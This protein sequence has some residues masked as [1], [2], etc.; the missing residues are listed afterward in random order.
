MIVIT[1][2][3]LCVRKKHSDANETQDL[4]LRWWCV[5]L[6][7]SRKSHVSITPHLLYRK[8]DISVLYCSQVSR[9]MRQTLSQLLFL[10]SYYWPRIISTTFW[11]L[12]DCI[13]SLFNNLTSKQKCF[14]HFGSLWIN[15]GFPREISLPVKESVQISG[16]GHHF[17]THPKI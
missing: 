7:F 4:H 16:T 8:C 6:K 3:E 12:R 17:L 5:P 15:D 2:E 14:K 13:I 1:I 9:D 10:K 11:E